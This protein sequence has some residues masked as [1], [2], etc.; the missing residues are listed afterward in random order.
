MIGLE[1]YLIAAPLVLA[2]LA[3]VATW[4]FVGREKG[5]LRPHTSGGSSNAS[6]LKAGTNMPF[7]YSQP[8]FQSKD[9]DNE[10]TL[11]GIVYSNVAPTHPAPKSSQ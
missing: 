8:V 1:V 5:I 3:V 10:Y 6:S 4:W 11:D 2:G 9:A 7:A